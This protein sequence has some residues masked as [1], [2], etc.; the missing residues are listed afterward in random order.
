M[1]GQS[2]SIGINKYS[3]NYARFFIDTIKYNKHCAM[4]L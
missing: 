1:H 2:D 3:C 4:K